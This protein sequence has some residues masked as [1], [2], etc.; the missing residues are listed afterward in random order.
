MIRRPPRS[1]LFP[2]TTLF[3]SSSGAFAATRTT[4]RARTLFSASTDESRA[5]PRMASEPA[6][7]PTKNL[8][9]TTIRLATR[10]PMK[11]RRTRA[12]S[13]RPSGRESGMGCKLVRRAG[14]VNGPQ[15]HP[16]QVPRLGD[17]DKL[18][19]ISSGARERDQLEPPAGVP[20]RVREHLRE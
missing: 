12:V 2:Y 3:R 7:R 16:L 6:R 17:V 1:T 8:A 4:I 9:A 14:L 15:Q 20:R 13:G 18:G 10:R 5:V 19:V 11:T